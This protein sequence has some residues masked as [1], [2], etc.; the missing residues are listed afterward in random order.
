MMSVPILTVVEKVIFLQNVDVF[1]DVPSEHLAYLASI[2][3]VEEFQ[4][5]EVIFEEGDASDAMY[6]VLSGKVRLHRGQQDITTAGPKEA[7]GTWVLLEQAPQVVTATV[8]EDV[9][10]LRIDR[11]DFIDLL[12]DHVQ[13][14]EAVLKNV[15]GRLRKL[16]DRVNIQPGGSSPTQA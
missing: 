7:F 6:L 3:T 1:A 15:A 16:L 12:S 10:L 13:I 5:S 2:A 8:T 4:E 11:E 9:V 14:T